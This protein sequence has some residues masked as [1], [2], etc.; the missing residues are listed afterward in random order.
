MRRSAWRIPDRR[1]TMRRVTRAQ[2]PNRALSIAATIA[3][4]PGRRLLFRE[5]E[6]DHQHGEGKRGMPPAV[7]SIVR[8]HAANDPLANLEPPCGHAR[9]N[10]P[11]DLEP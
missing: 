11:K 3:H 1:Q 9:V 2:G 6:A 8:D 7:V 4:A 10:Q 5:G